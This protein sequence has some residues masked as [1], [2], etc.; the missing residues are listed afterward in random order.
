MRVGVLAIV[1]SCLISLYLSGRYAT[2]SGK[3]NATAID[4]QSPFAV[5]PLAPNLGAENSGVRLA[6]GV[7]DEVFRDL[8]RASLRYQVLLFPPQEL[9]PHRQ[10][11]F[12]R[13]FAAL[14]GPLLT[15]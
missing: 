4:L 8:H 7:S 5:R 12:A 11:R 13:T 10:V 9:P 6:D 1:S 2:R 15:P 14:H 3:M